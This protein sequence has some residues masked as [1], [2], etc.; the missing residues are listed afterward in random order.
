MSLEIQ[1][2]IKGRKRTVPIVSEEWTGTTRFQIV[3][4]KLLEWYRWVKRKTHEHPTYFQTRFDLSS[5]LDEVTPETKRNQLQ[6]EHKKMPK[7]KEHAETGE[8]QR[9]RPMT[10]IHYF[11]VILDADLKLDKDTAPAPPCTEDDSRRKPQAGATSIDDKMRSG[12][13]QKMEHA[14]SFH[15]DLVHKP[16]SVPDALRITKANAVVDNEWEK[17]ENSSV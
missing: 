6:H 3:R 5:S 9:Y 12:Q 10:R 4:A 15:Y 2:M 17:L 16:V 1:S 8:S 13:I 7:C 11:K 14:E